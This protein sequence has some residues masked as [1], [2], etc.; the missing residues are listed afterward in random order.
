[1][2]F[3]SPLALLLTAAIAVPLVLHLLRRKTGQDLEFPAL[4]YLLRAQREFSRTLKLRNL[5]LMLIRVAIVLAV[6][7]AAARPVGRMIGGGHPPTALAVVLDNSLSSSAVI[8]GQPVL[9]RLKDA[10]RAALGRSS[11]GD[12]AWL[13][14]A[15]GRVV[16]GDIAAVRDALD[17]AEAFGGAGDL[18]AAVSRAV[19][20]VRASGIPA[21]QVAVLTDGQATSWPTVTSL[22]GVHLTVYAPADAAPRNRAVVR[23]VP[24]P[25]HWTPRGAVRA[26]TTSADSATY[27]VTLGG[28]A[29]A[30]G[31]AP[32]GTEVTARVQPTERGWLAGAVEL[33]PDELRGDDVRWFAAHVGAAPAVFVEPGVGA[34]ARTALD[35]LVQEGRVT[36]GSEVVIAGAEAARKPAVLFAP[37]DPVQVGA[38]NRAL[39]RAGIP[40]RLGQ[41]RD[42]PA[43]VKGTGVDGVTAQRWF[44]LEPASEAGEAAAVDTLATVGGEPWIVAGDGYVI[45][46]SALSTDA[47]D[48]PL[49]ASWVPWIGGVISDRLGGDAGAVQL[50]AP[51]ATVSRPLWARELEWPDG[52]TH[53]VST[54][55][56][57]A[58]ERAGVY[59]WRRGTARA[60]ALVV[61]PEVSESDLTRLDAA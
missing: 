14:T 36:R 55:R 9:A 12:R 56:L 40:W 51:G 30:R 18:P 54:S 61:N 15:D 6:A 5:L 19:Q 21:Q 52:S 57:R 31:T 39:Q 7:L 47:T 28:R 22:S 3:L 45:V 53:A 10:G 17:R 13:V 48:L 32:P 35:A 59:F 37:N 23:A 2:T 49:R 46:A 4:R 29:I 25:P 11:G 38:A 43:P 34:F 24:E 26:S 41:R 1:M 16:G 20:L 60:G 50:A 8:N 27:R 42:G 58:P 44:A 33:E